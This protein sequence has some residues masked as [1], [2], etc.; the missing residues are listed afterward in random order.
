MLDA[1]IKRLLY[2]SCSGNHYATF[3]NHLSLS[4]I[5]TPLDDEDNTALH[6]ATFHG[7]ADIIRLLLRYHANRTV[8][9]NEGKTPEQ[10]IT[11]EDIKQMFESSSLQFASTPTDNQIECDRR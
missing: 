11:D 2:D 10:M 4:E 9:N 6:I 7:Y 8:V 1:A 3:R 5:N